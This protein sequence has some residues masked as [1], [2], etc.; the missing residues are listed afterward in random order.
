MKTARLT[1]R[2]FTLGDDRFI[3]R[4]LNDPSFIDNIG[5]KGVRT[6]DDA[7]E[8]LRDGPLAS[9]AEHGFG[10]WCVTRTADAEPLGMCGL[11]QREFLDRPDIGYA[12]LP[13][14]TGHGYATEACS[15][16]VEFAGKH[17]NLSRIYAYV[18]AANE[19]SI[20]LLDKL[21]FQHERAMSLP[22][23]GDEVILYRRDL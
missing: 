2:E 15:A 13:E 4:L 14:H 11:L 19:P 5:D 9:Y 17:L 10:L 22:E 20:K 16:V 21:R 6:L 3:V 23:G 7:R 8:Y 1:L 12:L 18:G